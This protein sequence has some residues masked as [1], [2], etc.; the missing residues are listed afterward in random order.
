MM[1]DTEI[2]EL[3]IAWALVEFYNMDELDKMA[4]IQCAIDLIAKHQPPVHP[5][6]HGVEG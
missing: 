5:K 3:S 2:Q 4:R 1:N 6:D